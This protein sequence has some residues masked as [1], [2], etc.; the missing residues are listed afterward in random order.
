MMPPEPPI[1]PNALRPSR[2]VDVSII[3]AGRTLA[4]E[5]PGQNTFSLR[6]GNIPPA[7]PSMMSR[8]VTPIT[9]SKLPGFWTSPLTVTMRVPF[10]FSVPRLAYSAPPWR[11]IHGTVD[12]VSTL[13]TAVGSPQAPLTAGDGGRGRG[14]AP[15]PSSAPG[16]ALSPP[17]MYARSP[18]HHPPPTPP[19][20]PPHSQPRGP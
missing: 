17:D 3:E 13:L 2:S 15:F 11:M 12:R 7:R 19:S 8:Y 4:D 5:P 18:P 14:C 16:R 6:P 9:I 20:P 1:V 10:A